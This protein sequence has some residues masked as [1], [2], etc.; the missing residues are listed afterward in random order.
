MTHVVV[1]VWFGMVLLLFGQVSIVVAALPS[2]VVEVW[3]LYRAVFELLSSPSI[4]ALIASDEPAAS[5]VTTS[6]RSASSMLGVAVGA[7]VWV[8][9]WA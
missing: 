5:P 4:S 9:A 8:W 7:Y 1:H 3:S 6:G 2:L